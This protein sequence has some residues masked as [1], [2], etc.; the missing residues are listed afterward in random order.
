MTVS[1]ADQVLAHLQTYQLTEAQPGE[2]RC[3][4]PLRPGANSQSFSV[5]IDGPEYGT[6]FD[7]VSGEKGSLYDLAQRLGIA[8]PQPQPQAAQPTKRG[9]ADLAD[10]AQAHGVPAVAYVRW[11]WQETTRDGRPVLS[12]PTITGLRYR[13][14]D[15]AKPTFSHAAGYQACWYGLAEAVTLAHMTGQPLVLCNGEPSVVAAQ[16]WGIAACCVTSSGEK[17]LKQKQLDALKAAWSG[18][19]L[20]ALD[21]DAKGR[22]TAPKLAAQVGGRAI[23]LGGSDG[24]DLADFGFLH[25]SQSVQVLAQRAA[26]A[27]PAT[28]AA[29]TPAPTIPPPMAVSARILGA[30]TQ[31]GYSFALNLLTGDIMVNGAPMTKVMAAQMRTALRDRAIKPIGAVDDVVLTEAAR[32]AYHPIRDYLEKLTWDGVPRIRQLAGYCT[33]TD[34]PIVYADGTVVPLLHVYLRRWLIGACAKIYCQAQNMMLVLVGPQRSGK[35]TL[36]RWLCPLPQFFLENAINTQDKDT[37]VRL[38]NYW[39]WEVAELDATTRKADVSALKD[40]ITRKDVTVRKA[41]GAYDVTQ[42]ATASLIGTVNESDGFLADSTGNRRFLVVTITAIDLAYQQ[43]DLQQIWAEAMHAYQAGESWEL[44]LEEYQAQTDA[45]RQHETSDILEGWIDRHFWIDMTDQTGMTTSDIIDHLRSKEVPV[46][47]DRQ[48]EMRIG[49]ILRR[50]GL[51]KQRQ[52]TG[53]IRAYRW[54]GLMT[55]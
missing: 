21:C 41:Y 9:Y 39:I 24:F 5:K 12:F 18:P 31:L 13:F 27:T 38:M 1:T 42:P 7:H 15:G 37:F 4:S 16:H 52:Q 3:N 49:S 46:N 55:K 25:Q 8:L 40:F 26:S 45:N 19:I 22:S 35:S 17:L 2:W 20:V 36:A 33:G 48:W 47:A 6:W 10:Y 14:L 32:F 53:L 51:T 29:S 28:A 23:D 44:S 34:S 11:S 43:L 50:R 54:Y 30:L